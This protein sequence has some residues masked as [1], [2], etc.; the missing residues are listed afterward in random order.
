ME[1]WAQIHLQQCVF[2]TIVDVYL[3]MEHIHNAVSDNEGTLKQLQSVYKIKFEYLAQGLAVTSFDS[4]IPKYISKTS[5]L[6]TT[7]QKS[8]TLS[9]AVWDEPQ[10]G[11][12]SV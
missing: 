3:V 11:V 10:R 9:Y 6:V 2:G 12:I 5:N 4:R 1:G 7:I 8:N